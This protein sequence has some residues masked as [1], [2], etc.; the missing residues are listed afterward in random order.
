MG[1]IVKFDQ[2]KGKYLIKFLF[3]HLLFVHECLTCM[4]AWA[5]CEPLVSAEARRGHQVP[6]D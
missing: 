1:M 3:K 4:Y 5:E 2:H 6:W